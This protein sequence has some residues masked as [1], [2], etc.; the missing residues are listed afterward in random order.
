VSDDKGKVISYIAK[1][2]RRL[3]ELHHSKQQDLGAGIGK[4]KLGKGVKIMG[5]VDRYGFPLAVCSMQPIIMKLP[6]FS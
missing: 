2:N 6:W 4:T 1:I 3:M 5:I